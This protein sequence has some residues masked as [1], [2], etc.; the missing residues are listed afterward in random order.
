MR[1]AGE[2]WPR[3]G[4]SLSTLDKTRRSRGGS[5]CPCSA[6]GPGAA[7]RR[8]RRSGPRFPTDVPR[9]PAPSGGD[10][11]AVSSKAIRMPSRRKMVPSARRPSDRASFF[12]E[13][14]PA[15]RRTASRRGPLRTLGTQ[16]RG[17]PARSTGHCAGRTGRRL[18]RIAE[19]SLPGQVAHVADKP[20]TLPG[21]VSSATCANAR[22]RALP[23]E[24]GSCV[25]G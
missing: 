17:G 9:S 23:L 2:S 5:R 12:P 8:T 18:T 4:N 14:G 7:R 16:R 1:A 6:T 13:P 3:R 20:R 19:P 21:R 22:P 15:S 24:R 10:A 25:R 11:V